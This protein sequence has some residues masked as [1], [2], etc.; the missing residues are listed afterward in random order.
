MLAKLGSAGHIWSQI[1]PI[2]TDEA[3]THNMDPRVESE[4]DMTSAGYACS[5]NPVETNV[6]PPCRTWCLAFSLE[7]L[8]QYVS[9][10][11]RASA[12]IANVEF[13]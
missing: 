4:P 1:S 5:S 13:T 9:R 11:R 3:D 2:E 7:P 6:T 10:G 8:G 12:Y